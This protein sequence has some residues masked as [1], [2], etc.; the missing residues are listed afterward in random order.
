MK[1]FFIFPIHL[2]SSYSFRNS[3]F[4]SQF[5]PYS[6]ENLCLCLL[7]FWITRQGFDIFFLIFIFNNIFFWFYFPNTF[8]SVLTLKFLW[9]FVQAIFKSS[10]ILIRSSIC[11]VWIIFVY[12][13]AQFRINVISI[14][15]VYE[16]LILKNKIISILKL[17]L[18]N[19]I[20]V[21][22]MCFFV[23]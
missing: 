8:Y 23:F 19:W 20:W 17:W 14:Y 13:L 11:H 12:Q 21:K 6:F 3:F 5:F 10:L 9:W 22:I 2:V 15:F 1:I 4:E 7:M 16:D 18:N